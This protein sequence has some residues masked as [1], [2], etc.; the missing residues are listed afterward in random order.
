VHVPYKTNGNAL[1][2]LATGRIQSY[3]TAS[4]SLLPFVKDNRLRALAYTSSDINQVPP[5]LRFASVGMPEL[6]GT[7]SVEILLGP[8]NMPAALVAQ[9]G[10]TIE[11]ILAMPDVKAAFKAQSEV[12]YYRNGAQTL[13]RLVY[14]Q[15]RYTRVIRAAGIR[16][17]S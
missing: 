8:A 15:D 7:C 14:D 10:S 2:D 5:A 17:E 3:F 13:E 6:D 9:L 11:K 12:P 4:A 1:T 16:M